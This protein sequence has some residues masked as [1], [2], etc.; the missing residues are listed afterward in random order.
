MAMTGCCATQLASVPEVTW[1]QGTAKASSLTVTWPEGSPP[2]VR[3]LLVPGVTSKN[4]ELVLVPVTVTSMQLTSLGASVTA[5]ISCGDGGSPDVSD[6][7]SG[8]V[9][10]QP[11][12]AIPTRAHVITTKR[13]NLRHAKIEPMDP[14]RSATHKMRLRNGGIVASDLESHN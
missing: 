4:C 1:A 12:K 7:A 5:R 11:A 8:D 13:S 14:S 6:D 2:T 10:R 9:A 3:L